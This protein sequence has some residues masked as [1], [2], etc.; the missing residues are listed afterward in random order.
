MVRQSQHLRS[1]GEI[2]C[3][4][5][6]RLG[7]WR[8]TVNLALPFIPLLKLLRVDAREGK[9]AKHA[10]VGGAAHSGRGP[11]VGHREQPFF[12][13]GG[14]IQGARLFAI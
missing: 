6:G 4:W 5:M 7:W 13:D 8:K 11:G 10:G 1:R 3:V 14:G 12:C 2:F 9:K